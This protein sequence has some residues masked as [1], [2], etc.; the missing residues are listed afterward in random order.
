L[1][2]LAHHNVLLVPSL[3][4]ARMLVSVR[5]RSSVWLIIT[6]RFGGEPVPC[7]SMMRLHAGSSF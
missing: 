6:E 5:M 1:L 4:D 3:L 7:Q 2:L